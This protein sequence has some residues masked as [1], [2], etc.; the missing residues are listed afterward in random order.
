MASILLEQPLAASHGGVSFTME[1]CEGLVI[2]LADGAGTKANKF[3]KNVPPIKPTRGR[4]ASDRFAPLFHHTITTQIRSNGQA[5]QSNLRDP[6]GEDAVAVWNHAVYGYK[7][8]LMEVEGGDHTVID[9]AVQ[10]YANSNSEYPS[11]NAESAREEYYNYAL[12]YDEDGEVVPQHETNDWITASGFIPNNLYELTS[13][14]FTGGGY[15]HNESI[16]REDVS[17]L[18]ATL[19]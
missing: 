3:L 11:N 19:P 10:I 9:I 16:R 15:Y 7:A 4:D 6:G 18:V 2:K 12:K 13:C 1:E 17:E 8:D 5:L 14:A